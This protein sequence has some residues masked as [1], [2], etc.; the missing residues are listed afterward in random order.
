[1]KISSLFF[2]IVYG[3]SFLQ[4]GCEKANNPNQSSANNQNITI[5]SAS[6]TPSPPT[7]TSGP[8]QSIVEDGADANVAR[9]SSELQERCQH[10]PVEKIKA[11]PTEGAAPLTVTFDGS[12]SYDPDKT[13]IVRWQWGFS[14]GTPNLIG[15]K[16][17]RHTFRKP[18]TY[19]VLLTV[20]NR[21]GE[22]NSDCG[23][24]ESVKITVSALSD[25]PKTK[26]VNND[27]QTTN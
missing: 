27:S 22:K 12:L 9:R 5:A 4:H 26:G 19:V 11:I 17:I 21:N 25:N 10:T 8:N 3:V 6:P 18:G 16:K 14:D 1:M 2:T 13:D 24:K 20:T 7:A 15:G 23:H